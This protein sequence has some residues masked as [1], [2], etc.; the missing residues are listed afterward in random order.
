MVYLTLIIVSITVTSRAL[1]V[2]GGGGAGGSDLPVSG[3]SPAQIEVDSAQINT[4][5]MAS[6]FMVVKLL[7]SF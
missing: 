3:I 5:A 1:G 6:F 2:A 4:T 7:L